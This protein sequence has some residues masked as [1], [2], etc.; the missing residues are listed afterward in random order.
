MKTILIVYLKDLKDARKMIRIIKK[1][2]LSISTFDKYRGSI[3][4]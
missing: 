1:V 4:K 2:C 3:Q